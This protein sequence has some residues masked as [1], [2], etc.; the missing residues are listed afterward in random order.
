M[1]PGRATSALSTCGARLDT[2]GVPIYEYF[3]PDNN[4]IYQFFAKTIAQGL[5]TPKCPDNAAY[6]MERIM[7][8]FAIT[9]KGGGEEKKATDTDAPTGTA[10]AGGAGPGSE[11]DDPRMEAAFN[12][13]ESEMGERR[14][15]RPSLDG[16]HDAAHVRTHRRETRRPDG[17]SG[18][19]AG[20]RGGS[21]E[22]RE[23]DGRRLS[24][25]WPGEGDDGFD[26]MGGTGGF[27]GRG[28][29]SRDPNLYDY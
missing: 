29:P 8:A 23:R 21:G 11:A 9:G 19:Q 26:G 27:G 16:S 24:R 28:A 4:R 15:E 6:R 3:C 22:T 17:G 7:S 5:T 12:Q 18:A 10:P 13:L 1:H 2:H 20:R 14:R 25:G